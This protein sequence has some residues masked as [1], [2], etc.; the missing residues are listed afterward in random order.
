MTFPLFAGSY[1]TV[2]EFLNF[3]KFCLSIDIGLYEVNPIRQRR[4]V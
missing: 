4:Q 3:E 2:L 1:W